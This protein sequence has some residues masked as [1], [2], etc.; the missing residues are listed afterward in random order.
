MGYDR[1]ADMREQDERFF[2]DVPLF[3]DFKGV[4]DAV[5]YHPLPDDWLLAA[6]DI[7]NSTDAITTGRYKAVNMAGA[8]VI[9][10]ILNALDHR[11]MPYVFGGDG[12]LVAVPGP[13]EGQTRA[14]LSAVRKW[15]SEELGLTLRVALVPVADIRA[16]GLDVRVARFRASDN[17]SYAMFTGGGASWAEAEM[18]AGRYDVE[19][20]LSGIEPNLNGLSCRWNP[21]AARNG[22]IVSII[23][24]P[25]PAGNV[26]AF[27]TLVSDI[28]A[29]TGEERQDT[30]P[31]SEETLKFD[32][33]SSGVG[34]ESRAAPKGRRMIAWLKTTGLVVLVALADR[35]NRSLGPFDP[36]RYKKEVIQNTDFRK[37]DDGL[38]MTVD[39]DADLRRR[40]ET[41]LR[42][43]Q[44][45]GICNFGMHV[46]DSALMTC[47]VVNPMQRDHVHFVD[48]G[49]GGY[50]MAAADLKA[51]TLAA[52][53]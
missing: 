13:F 19:P 53:A 27:Q 46:Q 48:G 4:A 3:S 11:E 29:L 41:R 8:S 50:A 28:V 2:R 6:A 10:A 47:M 40:V 25:G 18:K 37:F 22:E 24:V 51:K 42:A 9:S 45:Q 1:L 12:A 43:A 16:K 44:S 39:M 21:I 36:K 38:K 15:V 32:F 52:A 34:P 26:Q 5:N 7:V 17:V 20:P 23:A 33:S 49:A 30:R 31:V 35:L 14:A